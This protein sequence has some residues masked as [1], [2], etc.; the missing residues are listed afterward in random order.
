MKETKPVAIICV[1]LLIFVWL[2][3][4]SAP[5][6]EAAEE[7]KGSW[8]Y[9]HD[10]DTT[11]L[12]LKSRGKATFH[13]VNYKYHT[14][15]SFIILSSKDEEIKLRYKV[16]GEG[17]LIYE[18]T[19]YEREDG[20]ASADGLIGRWVN[21]ENKWSFEFTE[22]GTFMEDGYFPGYYY[23][24]EKGGYAKLIYNDQF[25]DTVL[26]YSIEGSTLTVE[27]PWQ[28]VRVE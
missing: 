26:Y 25:E 24:N 8:A 7:L 3:G 1:L 11:I 2:I 17:I 6:D 15:G 19:V 16:D 13:D 14:D 23:I 10:P 20:N 21:K 9:N 28:M 22:E 12:S 5:V 27:Y 18:T 4:C